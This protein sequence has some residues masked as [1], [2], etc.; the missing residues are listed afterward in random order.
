MEQEEI[1]EIL[2]KQ[3]DGKLDS[4]LP[5]TANKKEDQHDLM[6]IVQTWS[7]S[8]LYHKNIYPQDAFCQRNILGATVYVASAA[9]LK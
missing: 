4:Y 2:T 8:L 5:K 6:N 1:S 7:H 9:P 3:D